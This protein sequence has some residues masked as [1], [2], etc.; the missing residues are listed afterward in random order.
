MIVCFSVSE[1]SCSVVLCRSKNSPLIHSVNTNMDLF[2]STSGSA[3]K[4][5]PESQLDNLKESLSKQ[6][7]KIGKS[8]EAT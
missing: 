7:K 2:S 8:Q 3:Q 6:I 1:E 5:A 4:M